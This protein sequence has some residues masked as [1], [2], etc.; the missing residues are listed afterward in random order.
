MPLVLEKVSL[1]S[2]INLLFQRSLTGGSRLISFSELANVANIPEEKVEFAIMKILCQGLV[3][4]YLDETMR[5]FKYS[6]V[7]PRSLTISNCKQL[8][9][10]FSQWLG[11]AELALSD[12]QSST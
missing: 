10:R 3:K 8:V 9:L 5:T 6:W 4:G 7:H 12:M 11:N 2:I 1:M